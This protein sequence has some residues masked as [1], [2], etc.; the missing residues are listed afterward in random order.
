MLKSLLSKEVK[1]NITIGAI[2]LKSNVTT[3]KTFRF[4][5]KSLF[6]TILVFTEAHSG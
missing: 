6:F 5:P 1:L 2:R 4:T 3:N